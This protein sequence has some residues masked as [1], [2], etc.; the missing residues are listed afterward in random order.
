MNS[1]HR[2][3]MLL[4][5]LSLC[6]LTP[7]GAVFAEDKS[8]TTTPRQSDLSSLL[9][10]I[11]K[12]ISDFTSLKTE[13]TQEKEMAMFKEKLVL[14]GRIYL[15]KPGKIAWHVDSPVRYSVLITDKL[16]RQW[17]EDTNKVQELS[18]AKNPIFQNVLNQLTVWFSG[19]YGSLLATNEVRVKQN[20]PLVL[21]F[22]P[23]EKN[24]SKKVIKSITI[25]F[26][27]DQKYL[28]QILIREVNG[29]VTT[30]N[31]IN[32]LLNVPLDSSSFE[33]KG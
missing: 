22:I 25:T 30:I 6:F 24:I 14:K 32:T 16:I 23:L 1:M 13:F 19:E 31:F 12:K 17:D 33:V 29:D 10:S 15:L 21:E 2:S 3:P 5:T 27:D 11:G 9:N 4:L 18:L 8:A 7:A 28:K 20:D 26:R